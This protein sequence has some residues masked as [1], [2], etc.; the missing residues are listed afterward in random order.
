MKIGQGIYDYIPVIADNHTNNNT[1]KGAV[2]KIGQGIY[3]YIPFIAET[4]RPTIILTIKVI[5]D[6]IPV[7]AETIRP[8]IILTITASVL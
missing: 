5:Y 2:A 8:T 6:Y 7:I 1:D 4:I 3:D